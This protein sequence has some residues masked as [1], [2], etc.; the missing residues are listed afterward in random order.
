MSD[1]LTSI[2]LLEVIT[3]LKENHERAVRRLENR[4]AVL[5]SRVAI[6]EKQA[7]DD[8]YPGTSVGD[9]EDRLDSIETIV[10]RIAK[11]LDA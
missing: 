3:Q 2:Q 9:L 8:A 5:Q 10:D 11:K 7:N 4:L 1:G 6:L